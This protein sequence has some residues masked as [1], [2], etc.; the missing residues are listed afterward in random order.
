MVCIY[1]S[2]ETQVINSRPQKRLNNIW[3]RRKCT[4]CEGIFTTSES[5][6]LTSSLVV[7]KGG[8][9]LSHLDARQGADEKRT[10]PYMKYG[11]G[12][13]QAATPGAK[14]TGRV[15][16]FA[17]KSAGAVRENWLEPFSRDKLFL[18]IYESCKHRPSA[19]T[20]A[21]ALTETIISKLLPQV[22][23]AT[24]PVGLI[25]EAASDTLNNFDRPAYIHYVAFHPDK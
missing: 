21:Q 8:P 6:D 4:A 16:G 19:M 18:S 15:S 13:P 9:G 24:L 7:I 2:G 22:Q 23:S 10:E 11:E 3:R 25:K 12:A 5:P 14:S 20:D 1:C 17:R